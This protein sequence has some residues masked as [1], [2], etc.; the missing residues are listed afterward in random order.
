MANHSTQEILKAAQDYYLKGEYENS[1]KII[2]E[3]KDHL[4]SGLFHYNLGSIYLKL[5]DFGPARFHLEKAK[6]DGFSYPML[7]NN[8][9]YIKL[10]PDV[11]DPT[12]SKNWKDYTIA[13]AIDIPMNFYLLYFLLG[14]SL[15]LLLLKKKW[16]QNKLLMIFYILLLVFPPIA[17]YTYEQGHNFAVALKDLSIH[18]GPSQIYPD[19][20]SIAAGSRVIVGKFY[21][22]WYYIVSPRNKSG[23]VKK[24]DLGFYD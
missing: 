6:E 8:L 9:E 10:Q 14:L 20:G 11:A 15:F 24:S 1:L 17:R 16:I 23:W 5:N 13:N 12:Y 21:D 19:Y 18:E 3:N 7:W 2:R 4:D 22:D